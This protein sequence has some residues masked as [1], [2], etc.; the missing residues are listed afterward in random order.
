MI[1][2][3][4]VIAGLLVVSHGVTLLG[5]ILVGSL[6]GLTKPDPQFGEMLSDPAAKWVRR[7]REALARVDLPQVGTQPQNR[8]TQTCGK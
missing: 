8:D 2:L 6:A 1:Y 7:N 5:G 3:F 4:A